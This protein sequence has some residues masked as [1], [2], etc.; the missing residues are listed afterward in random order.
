VG[1]SEEAILD[2][3]TRAL[4]DSVVTL[5][6]EVVDMT[7]GHVKATDRQPDD[8]EGGY[9]LWWEGVTP[10][11]YGESEAH[12]T[13]GRNAAP[14]LAGFSLT[15]SL[16]T[17]NL[18]AEVV[19]WRNLPFLIFLLAATFLTFTVQALFW[20]QRSKVTPADLMMWYPDWMHDYRRDPMIE[21]LNDHGARYRNWARA[22][23]LTYALG[24]LCLLAGLTLLAVPPACADSS[25]RWTAVAV[26]SLATMVEF[27]WVLKTSWTNFGKPKIKKKKKS[28]E[29]PTDQPSEP[30]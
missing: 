24:L 17:L 9:R 7:E 30:Q 16:Q 13:I 8:G 26:G 12:V 10:D 19:H 11:H 20:A 22:A 6:C 14:F 1:P 15:A 27:A 25:L 18:R 3:S 28:S 23:S 4:Q 29:Q 5:T 21:I 2:L